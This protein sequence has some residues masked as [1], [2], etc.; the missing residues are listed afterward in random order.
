MAVPDS[1]LESSICKVYCSEM[2]TRV[3]DESLAIAAG[4]GYMKEYPYERLLRDARIS[5]IFEGTN[6]VLRCFIAL[7]GMQGPGDRLA[8]LSDFIKWPLKGYGLAIDFVV[9]KLRT[10]VYGGESIDGAHAMLKRETVAFEDSVPELAQAVEKALRKH[11]KNISEMQYT[12]Q[13]VADVVIDLY[14]MI[15]CI[16]RTT[17]RPNSLKPLC[18]GVS[19]DE[20]AQLVFRKCVSV[21][22][23]TPSR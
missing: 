4:L 16:S 13:R 3:V 9:D 7:S 14:A 2:L 11:G 18:C 19:V 8:Q 15:A 6:D 21:I 23:R 1:T 12:Q 20:S 5:L 22:E 10:Q 17:A